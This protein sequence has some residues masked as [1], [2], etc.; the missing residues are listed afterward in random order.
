MSTIHRTE[1]ASVTLGSYADSESTA[2]ENVRTFL[3]DVGRASLPDIV[4]A[5]SGAWAVCHAAV[6]RLIHEGHIMTDQDA[7]P[8]EYVWRK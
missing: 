8:W 4:G 7:H 1:T 5:T 2:Y 6:R 3:Q